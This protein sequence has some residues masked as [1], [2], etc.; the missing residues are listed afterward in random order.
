MNSSHCTAR[1]VGL[2]AAVLLFAGCGGSGGTDGDPDWN[3]DGSSSDSSAE[4]D[5]GTGDV[6]DRDPVPTAVVLVNRT[7][8]TLYYQKVGSD[9]TGNPDW[10]SVRRSGEELKLWTKCSECLCSESDRGHC[11]P[12]PCPGACAVAETETLEPG[13]EVTYDWDG[14]YWKKEE[15]EKGSCFRNA[16]PPREAPMAAEFCWGTGENRPDTP[17]GEVTGETCELVPFSYGVDSEVIYEIQ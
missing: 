3:L 9:C 11:E 16:V 12:Q 8:E 6:V 13:E 15:R 10:F 2:L 7:D 1:V 5:G 4:P 17:G 14:S